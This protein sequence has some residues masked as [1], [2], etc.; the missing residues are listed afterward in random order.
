MRLF[1]YPMFAL[2]LCLAGS[3]AADAGDLSGNPTVLP[4]GLIMIGGHE[5]GSL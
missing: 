5:G 1:F 4:S 2:L 3:A